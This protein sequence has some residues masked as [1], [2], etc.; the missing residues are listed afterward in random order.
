VVRDVAAEA[1]EAYL[2]EALSNASGLESYGVSGYTVDPGAY[3]SERRSDAVV[4]R[5]RLGYSYQCEGRIADQEA[6]ATYRITTES[7]ERIGGTF[8]APN[9]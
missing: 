4:V 2:Y 7:V 1:E 5:V 9:C 6:K 8:F 3:V